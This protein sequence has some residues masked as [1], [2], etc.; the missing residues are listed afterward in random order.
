[1]NSDFRDLLL[2]FAD[3]GVDFVIVGAHAVGVHGLPRAT[4]DLDVFIRPSRENAERV[5]RALADFGA[6]LDSVGVTFKDFETPGTVYQIGVPPRRIDILTEISGVTF[7]E[8]FEAH[9][10]LDFE[11][12]TIRYIGRGALIRN[13]EASGRPKD[14]ADVERLQSQRRP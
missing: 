11:G 8:A 3:A 13:K 2:G 14:L 12:R 4:Q 9:G 6:T 10:S 1:L 5:Y 7:D